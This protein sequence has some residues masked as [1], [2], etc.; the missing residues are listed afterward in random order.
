MPGNVRI[1]TVSR[2][3]KCILRP[4]YYT[5][6]EKPNETRLHGIVAFCNA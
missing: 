5:S 3:L 6:L 4:N 2:L 1:A